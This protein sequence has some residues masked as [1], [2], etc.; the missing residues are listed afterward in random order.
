[1]AFLLFKTSTVTGSGCDGDNRGV[2]STRRVAEERRP[3][4]TCTWEVRHAS[5]GQVEAGQR[6]FQRLVSRAQ[7]QSGTALALAQNASSARTA[8]TGQSQKDK[9]GGRLSDCPPDTTI[10]SPPHLVTRGPQNTGSDLQC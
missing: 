8:H 9:A 2:D 10:N 1:M 3:V 6:L 5:I 7:A 4:V